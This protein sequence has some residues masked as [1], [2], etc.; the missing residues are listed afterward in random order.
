MFRPDFVVVLLFLIRYQNAEL[1]LPKA[2]S[3]SRTMIPSVHL[4][5]SAKLN[6]EPDSVPFLSDKRFLLLAFLACKH[7]WVPRDQLAFLF[8]DDTD[9]VSARKNLRHLLSRVRGLEFVALEFEDLLR[10]KV[11]TGRI[12]SCSPPLNSKND[13]QR[14]NA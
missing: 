4:L 13:P 11:R 5:G 14:S 2:V 9:S 8:W 3:M 1:L 7:D 10:H 6:L 12:R